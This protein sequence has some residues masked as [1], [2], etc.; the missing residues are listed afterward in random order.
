MRRISQ[1]GRSLPLRALAALA[2]LCLAGSQA[3]LVQGRSYRTEDQENRPCSTDDD[4]ALDQSCKE[5]TC[6]SAPGC[7]ACGEVPHGKATCFHGACLVE[8]CETGYRDANGIFQD[9][10]E[11][12]C[13]PTGAETC[14]GIDDDC[15]GR[16][17]EDFDLLHDASNCGNCGRA[18]PSAP[19]AEA[20]CN[21]GHCSLQC[22]EGWYDNNGDLT[23]GC[24][25]DH[26]EI[27]AGGEEI[28]DLRDN[29]CDGDTD[30]GFD[31]DLPTSCGPFCENCEAQM[32]GAE[33]ACHQGHCDLVACQPGHHDLDQDPANGCEYACIVQGEETCNGTDDDCNGLTDEGLTCSC[34]ADMVLV[35]D[36][37]CMD[38]YEASRPDATATSQGT[39]SSRATSRPGVMPW[40]NVSFAEAQAA[41]EA[42]GK[43]LC[44]PAEWEQACKGPAQTTYSYGDTYD[45]TTCNGI[46]AFC[47]CGLST[48]C[49]EQDPCPYPHCYWDCGAAFHPV[50]T[51]GF[52]DCTNAY[53]LFDMNGNVWE[54]VSD[55]AG[56]GGAFNCGDSESLHRCDYVA[57]WGLEARSNF[58]FRCCCTDCPTD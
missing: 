44:S 28:C 19:H 55:G 41:C 56:R 39:D 16:T 9:G 34:P 42:A 3:C 11:Y 43:R 57:D 17:D 31:K 1:P 10:C 15:D 8:A 53:G 45:P 22:Q 14:N 30:E 58:G 27:S 21:Q 2:A 12:A 35:D 13:S 6:Q 20:V 51:G 24:E 49:A 54:R 32:P 25:S 38:R 50:P 33:V 7:A 5:G 40:L 52:P 29:D 46:D 23:D 36:L 37:F 47:N 26:C 48:S 4:C 18:C